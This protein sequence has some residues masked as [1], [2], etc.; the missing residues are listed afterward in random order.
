LLDDYDIIVL[1][2]PGLDIHMICDKLDLSRN[3]S[4]TFV[5]AHLSVYDS[6]SLLFVNFP[7]ISKLI[8]SLT[9]L[10]QKTY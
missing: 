1:D 3:A 4:Q 9:Y 10:P 6:F 2:L 7:W 8:S 5:T